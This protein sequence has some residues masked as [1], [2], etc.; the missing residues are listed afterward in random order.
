VVLVEVGIVV[1]VLHVPV[2]PAGEEIRGEAVLRVDP[3]VDAV[4]IEVRPVRRPRI[5]PPEVGEPGGEVRTREVEAAHGRLAVDVV[6]REVEL[7]A[8][9]GMK[10]DTGRENVGGRLVRDRVS[11]EPFLAR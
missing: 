3:G 10:V 2:R 4:E 6:E 1:V 11:F 7:E 9:G 5:V 8:A